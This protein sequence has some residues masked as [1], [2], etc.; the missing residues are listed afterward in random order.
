MTHFTLA[1]TKSILWYS[2][3]ANEPQNGAA[4]S[5]YSGAAKQKGL[6]SADYSDYAD[7]SQVLNYLKAGRRQRGLLINFGTKSLQHQRFIWCLEDQRPDDAR[8]EICVI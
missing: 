2:P 8:K 7:F 6:K 5:D 1:T 3:E 4:A